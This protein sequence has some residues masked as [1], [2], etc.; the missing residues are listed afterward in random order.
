MDVTTLVNGLKQRDEKTF[1]L[2]V[3]EYS[4]LIL[5]VLT[6]ILSI[7]HEKNYIED[8]Y[9]ETLVCIWKNIDS[10]Q[11]NSSFK[12]WVVAITKYRALDFKRTLKKSNNSLEIDELIVPC[13]EGVEDEYLNSTS[14]ESLLNILSP[15][16]NVDKD[17]FLMHY[18]YGH[19]A[20]TIS[21]TMHMSEDNVFKRLSRGR[22]RLKDHYGSLNNLQDII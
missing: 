1:N 8:A 4:P 21:S 3:D 18:Y 15:L 6:S 17:I 11:E 12:T 5:K 20:K 9:N 19:N 2:F 14:K 22:K 7:G 16:K 10:F 13:S